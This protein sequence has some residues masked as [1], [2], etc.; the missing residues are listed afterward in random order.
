MLV[1]CMCVLML[2]SAGLLAMFAAAG[3]GPALAVKERQIVVLGAVGELPVG[4]AGRYVTAIGPSLTV[5]R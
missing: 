5:A 2:S 3:T 1:R 4:Q